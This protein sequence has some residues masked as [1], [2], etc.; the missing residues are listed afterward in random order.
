MD[1]SAFCEECGHKLEAA[2]QAPPRAGAEAF[3]DAPQNPAA[4]VALPPP[5]PSAP[6][7]DWTIG[8]SSSPP[9]I[10]FLNPATPPPMAAP[11]YGSPAVGG[12]APYAEGLNPGSAPPFNAPAAPPLPF[13]PA[14]P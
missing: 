4:S 11:T 5:N 3:P 13:N 1:G 12:G 2:G 14:Q 7:A 10:P 9:G 6:A 8:P